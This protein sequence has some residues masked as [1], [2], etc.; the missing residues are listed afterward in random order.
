MTFAGKSVFR[1]RWAL[2]GILCVGMTF[3]C[4]RITNEEAKIV[5]TW[6]FTGL[7]ATVRLVLRRDHTIVTLMSPADGYCDQK[8][9]ASAWGKWRLDGNE[10]VTDEEVFAVPGYLSSNRQVARV[11]IQSVQENRLVRGDGRSD[12]YRVQPRAQQYSRLLAVLYVFLSGM[13]FFAMIY[14]IR[15]PYLRSECAFLAVAAGFAITWSSL[16]L[17]ADFG[18]SG[19]IIISTSS[20]RSLLLTT[21][22]ARVICL[23]LFTVGFVKLAFALRRKPI[24]PLEREG[25]RV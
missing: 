16:T 22:V 2:F 21:E 25:G 17:V 9:A 14:G 5:G 18:Q 6:E 12:L 10:I 20:M 13:V 7:D 8:W 3:S 19:A 24:A 23:L 15:T 4:Q 11:P 1:H